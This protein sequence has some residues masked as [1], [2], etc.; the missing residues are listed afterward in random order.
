MRLPLP[1]E[2]GEDKE[3]TIHGCEAVLEYVAKHLPSKEEERPHKGW[4]VI[5]VPEGQEIF[6][7]A[8]TELFKAIHDEYDG[9]V[10]KA[11]VPLENIIPCGPHGVGEIVIKPGFS[12]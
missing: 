6:N 3:E 11:D 7:D 9:K 10:F 5:T 4:S 1:T 2:V 12:P 8:I